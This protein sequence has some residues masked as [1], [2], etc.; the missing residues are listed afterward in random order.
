MLENRF[1]H[2][3]KHGSGNAS[4]NASLAAGARCG[5]TLK[6][7]LQGAGTRVEGTGYRVQAVHGAGVGSMDLGPRVQGAAAGNRQ[8]GTGCT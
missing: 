6:S 8:H 5:L 4:G 1:P 2:I 7:R 3:P